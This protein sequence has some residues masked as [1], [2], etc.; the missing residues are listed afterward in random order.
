MPVAI[1]DELSP[2]EKI[3]TTF[4]IIFISIDTQ[5]LDQ[6]AELDLTQR[7]IPTTF[8][9]ELNRVLEILSLANSA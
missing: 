3:V 1:L 4:L 6:K 8:D 9:R 2:T 5:Y 7:A